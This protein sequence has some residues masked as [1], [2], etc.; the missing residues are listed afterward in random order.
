N[1]FEQNLRFC[2]RARIAISHAIVLGSIGQ[3]R[4]PIRPDR[5]EPRAVKRRPKPRKLLTEPRR[6]VREQL[7][8]QQQRCAERA[9]R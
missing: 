2:P 9:L 1:A 7:R 4:L 3:T 8:K 6:V 5:V